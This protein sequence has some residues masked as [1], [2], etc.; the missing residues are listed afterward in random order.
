MMKIIQSPF[1]TILMHLDIAFSKA[2][3]RFNNDGHHQVARNNDVCS[4][5]YSKYV[6]CVFGRESN[7]SC[8]PKI[9]NPGNVSTITI[10]IQT[11]LYHSV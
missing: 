10:D 4:I 7:R 3:K 9:S 6:H 2:S 1:L 8:G 5:V 11:T